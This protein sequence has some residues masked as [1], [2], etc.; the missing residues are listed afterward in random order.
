M[1]GRSK[2]G[3]LTFS[4]A[5]PPVS[6]SQSQDSDA[7]LTTRAETSHSS[8]LGWLLKSGLA[9][10]SGKM[11]PVSCHPTEDGTLVPS[12]GR[13]RNSGMGSPTECWTLS[14]PEWTA[15]LVPSH[16]G[17]DVCSLSD[18]LE[19]TPDVPQKYYLSQKAC[20]GIL[21]RAAARGKALPEALRLALEAI[22][23]PST[24]PKT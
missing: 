3:Q 2:P 10:S 8:I 1:T 22:A 5:E 20:A 7:D 19:E 12:S 17:D 4:W 16:S 15:T 9:T 11:C 13:W 6:H 24:G 23:T 18:V 14:T 21:R